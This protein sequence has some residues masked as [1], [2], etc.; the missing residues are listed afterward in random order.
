M[1][2]ARLTA[3][4]LLIM[5]LCACSAKPG[6]SAATPTPTFAP[7]SAPDSGRQAHARP[8]AGSYPSTHQSGK[9]PMT[10]AYLSYR[11]RV[12]GAKR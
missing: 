5:L 4:L 3:C 2:Y 7:N 11:P 8:H 1:K 9:S 10:R 12:L 6:L